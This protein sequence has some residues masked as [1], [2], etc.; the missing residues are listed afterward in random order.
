MY[1][2]SSTRTFKLSQK[3]ESDLEMSIEDWHGIYSLS[4]CITKD[5]KL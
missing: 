3:L 1:S 4:F 5:T 2:E